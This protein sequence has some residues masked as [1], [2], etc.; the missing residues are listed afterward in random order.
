MSA[1]VGSF[2]SALRRGLNEGQVGFYV[3][4]IKG[5]HDGSFYGARIAGSPG[6]AIGGPMTSMVRAIGGGIGGFAKGVGQ[7]VYEKLTTK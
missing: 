7:D 6:A 1:D 3:G 2:E 4:A 5:L